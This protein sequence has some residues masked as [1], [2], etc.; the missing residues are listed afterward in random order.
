MKVSDIQLAI[1]N[2]GF[3]GAIYDIVYRLRHKLSRRMVFQGMTLVPEDVDRSFL[4]EVPG[5]Q[6]G[7]LTEAQLRAFAKVPGLELDDRFLD[8]ALAR[9][10]RCWALRA[11]PGAGTNEGD[12]E[13][14]AYGWYSRKPTD[15]TD[16]LRLAFDPA[17]VYMYKGFT[18]HAHRGKRLHGI[19]MA[20]ALLAYVQEG[21]KGI[22]SQVEANNFSSLKSTRRLGYKDVGRLSASRCLGRWRLKADPSCAAYGLA[23][24]LRKP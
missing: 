15:L 9:G 10:D 5:Y 23:L 21:V 18:A 20:R 2:A 1:R 24:E 6:Q 22:V 17:W 8:E 16:D 12:G 3:R 7:F 4:A 13:L 19:G 14:A 11:V